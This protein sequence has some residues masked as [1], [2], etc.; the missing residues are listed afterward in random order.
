VKLLAVKLPAFADRK[1]LAENGPG[2]AVSATAHL[3][4]LL[5]LLL[6]VRHTAPSPDAGL[7]TV[8]VEIVHLGE[9]TASPPAPQHSTAPSQ[10]AS[11]QRAPA[12]HSPPTGYAPHKPPPKDDLENRLNALSKLRAPETDTQALHGAGEQ[13]SDAQSDAPAGSS[14]SYSLRDFL[15]AQIERRWSLDLSVLGERRIV[16]ALRVVMKRSGAITSAEIVDKTR[17]ASDK[18]FREVAMSARNA[19]LLASPIAL[20]P[21]DYPAETVLTL[22]LDPRSAMR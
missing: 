12:A 6:A 8:L 14:A 7:R 9:S 11:V 15:R 5:M 1:R 16:V 20:P 2:I 18:Q 19:I 21:G 4:V 13:R 10:E 22:S 3:A 17:Y